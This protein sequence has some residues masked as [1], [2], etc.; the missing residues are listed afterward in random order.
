MEGLIIHCIFIEKLT[1]VSFLYFFGYISV[2]HIARNF[3]A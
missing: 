3:N 1:I 2:N